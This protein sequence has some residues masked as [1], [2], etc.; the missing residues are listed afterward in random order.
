[1][2]G[3][4]IPVQE[5]IMKTV[6]EGYFFMIDIPT[7]I[8]CKPSVQLLCLEKIL[9]TNMKC[10]LYTPPMP[11]DNEVEIIS[12]ML[13]MGADQ[14]YLRRHAADEIYW[15]AYV[16]QFPMG[17]A[18]KMICQDFRVLH[19]MDLGGFHFN[20]QRL[21]TLAPADLQE[22]LSM[23]KMLGKKSSATV[24]SLEAL[25][26]YDGKFDIL[27]LAPLFPSISK[28]GYEQHWDF[29][30]LKVYMQKRNSHTEIHG[31]GGIDADKVDMAHLIGLD[32]I[33]VLGAVWEH[34]SSAL[35]TFKHILEKCQ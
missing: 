34:P 27:L 24:R 19:E 15:M 25:Q 1:V 3:V 32:G 9:H 2:L 6:E 23:L 12:T 13:D 22:N 14:L 7:L 17:H 21:Q 33:A 20:S 31:L 10:I 16:E 18:G 5:E 30:A 26:A 28:P 8:F 4:K 29:E 11:I 35:L